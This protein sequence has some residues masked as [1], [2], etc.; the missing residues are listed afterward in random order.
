VKQQTAITVG[1]LALTAL[2][3]MAYAGQAREPGTQGKA[4]AAA[5]GGAPAR[6]PLSR[7]EREAIVKAA[8][9]AVHKSVQIPV[10][11]RDGDNISRIFWGEAIE[12]LRPLRVVNDNMNVMI[13][14]TEDSRGEAGLYV[15]NV[16]SSVYNT[17]ATFERLSK[18]ED[19]RSLGHLLRYRIR[20]K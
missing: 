14:L 17:R 7:G 16:I 15:G 11:E 5:P 4:K 20:K 2:A 6:P 3:G 18:P 8:I 9:T 12:K 1:V 10:H 13:V 19:R